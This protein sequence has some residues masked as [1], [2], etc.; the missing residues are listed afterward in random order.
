MAS[1]Q[2]T[3]LKLSLKMGITD[4]FVGLNALQISNYTL[5]CGFH[6]VMGVREKTQLAPPLCID[7][8]ARYGAS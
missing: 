4:V 2:D 6:E 1:R 5:S 7:R 3:N 8:S